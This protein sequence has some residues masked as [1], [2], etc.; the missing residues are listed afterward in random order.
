MKHRMKFLFTILPLVALIS[1]NAASAEIE[2]VPW[3]TY[4]FA[5]VQ[6]ERSRSRG[7]EPRSDGG[8]RMWVRGS[9]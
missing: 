5:D 2:N 9:T 4:S 6:A 3:Q 1:V 8:F 7:I